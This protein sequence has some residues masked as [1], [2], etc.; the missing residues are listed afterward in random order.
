MKSGTRTALKSMLILAG[1]GA[2]I[3]VVALYLRHE[4]AQGI[5]GDVRDPTQPTARSSSS[6]LLRADLEACGL[7]RECRR[8]VQWEFDHPGEQYSEEAIQAEIAASQARAREEREHRLR[9]QY[10]YLF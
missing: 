4:R 7:D 6:P 5:T 10:A 9:D 3:Y 8:R 1:V 2:G